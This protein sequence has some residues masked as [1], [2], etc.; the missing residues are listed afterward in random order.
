[1]RRRLLAAPLVVAA[2]VACSS[3][4]PARTS[5]GPGGEG[6]APALTVE[7]FLQA[8]NSVAQLSTAGASSSAQMADEM[9]TMARLFGTARGSVL[10]LYPRDEVEQRMFILA[11]MLQHHDYRLGGERAVPGRAGSAVQVMV[12]I[13]PRAGSDPVSLPFTVVR[14]SRG[15]WLIEK[16]D[17]EKLTRG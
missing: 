2:L 1:M 14:T 17:V 9:E 13:Q 5:A 4:P 16:I 15:E 11:R 7:R 10:R 12:D 3:N 6:V 8:A